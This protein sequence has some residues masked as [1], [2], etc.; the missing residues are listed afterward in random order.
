[1]LTPFRSILADYSRFHLWR[2][3]AGNEQ[4]KTL[5]AYNA[6]QVAPTDLIRQFGAELMEL[7]MTLESVE[8][9][10]D[11]SP[12]GSEGD[13]VQFWL[14]RVV[15]E[16]VTLTI[17]SIRQFV[18]KPS[19]PT[20]GTVGDQGVALSVVPALEQLTCDLEYLSNVLVAVSEATFE[21]TLGLAITKLQEELER[22]K[23]AGGPAGQP[24]VLASIL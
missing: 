20:H 24:C 13:A 14:S 23:A 15:G 10:L 12:E 7:P 22:L 6:G 16:I 9:D 3:A 8:G 17:Q 18:I 2:A 1:M 11:T 5:A 21:E 19:P 4:V